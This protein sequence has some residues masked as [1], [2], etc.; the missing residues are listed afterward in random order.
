MY[1]YI[2]ITFLSLF[3]CYSC[4]SNYHYETRQIYAVVVNKQY[5]ESHT[6]MMSVPYTVGKVHG[7]R[8]QPVHHPETYTVYFQ[9]IDT[10]YTNI[11]LKS[12]EDVDIDMYTNVSIGDTILVERSVKIYNNE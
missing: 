3:I 9:F 5:T 4:D 2:F 1:K 11:G 12:K 8:L 7:V 6:T 10:C